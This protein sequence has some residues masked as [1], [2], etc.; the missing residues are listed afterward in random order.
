MKILT[1]AL[2][3]IMLFG[4]QST[5]EN[6]VVKEK[7]LISKT[8]EHKDIV[9]CGFPS[10]LT[11]HDDMIV[12]MDNSNSPIV[13]L[14]NREDVSLINSF[15]TK[16]RGP[17]ELLTPSQM[18]ITD[19]DIIELLDS[20]NCKLVYYTIKGEHIKDSSLMTSGHK[21]EKTPSIGRISDNT[22]WISNLKTEFNL[23]IYN[24]NA[25]KLKSLFNIPNSNEDPYINQMSI[26]SNPEN[27]IIVGATKMGDVLQIYNTKTDKN[28][29]HIGEGGIPTSS[30]EGQIEGYLDVKIGEDK[31]YALFSGVTFAEIFDNEELLNGGKYI[32]TFSFEGKPLEKYTLDRQIVAFE[33]DPSGDTIIGYDSNQE[34]PICEFKL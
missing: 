12:I 9:N 20:D 3:A 30:D 6:N 1:L 16:G 2:L 11:L 5:P 21:I 29:I 17:K 4:C 25:E 23:E 31:V 7:N 15:G 10:A 24:D 18:R 8:L 33:I 13:Q 19:N 27:G 26:E 32:Y 14:F 34:N 22:Y 28:F